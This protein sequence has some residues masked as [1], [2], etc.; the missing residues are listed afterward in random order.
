[1]GG[2]GALRGGTCRDEHR[3]LYYMLAN[4]TAIKKY[5]KKK[6][7]DKLRKVELMEYSTT[8]EKAA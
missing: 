1:M 5:T 6:I 3:V 4:Q 7:S 2:L 8:E